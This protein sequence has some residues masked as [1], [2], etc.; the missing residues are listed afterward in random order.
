MKT[1]VATKR[2]ISEQALGHEDIDYY[3]ERIGL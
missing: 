1:P 3:M 2:L